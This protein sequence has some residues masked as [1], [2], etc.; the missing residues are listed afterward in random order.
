MA[1]AVRLARDRS[2]SAAVEFALLAPA[3]M[4]LA[5][6]GYAF[7]A[8]HAGAVSLETGAAAAA[9]VAMVGDRPGGET[10]V[11]AIRRVVT[12]HVCPVGGGFCY[13]SADRQVEGVDGL[14]APLGVEARAYVDPRNIGRPEP[15][16]DQPPYNGVRDPWEE[17]VDLN[18]NGQ[19]DSDMGAAGP[20]GS[21]DYVVFTLSFAQEV[22]HPLLA[23]LT[24]PLITHSAR[25]VVRNEPF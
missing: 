24:G 7:L 2:G 3:A 6:L 1:G 14:L 13:W 11:A 8:L 9:R 25:V 10:R 23:P 15:F 18:G 16:T 19:W 12:A 4:I 17:Y 5:T 22:R 20:G 21:G